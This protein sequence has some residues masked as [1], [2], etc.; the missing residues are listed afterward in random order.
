M[1]LRC[2]E[3]DELRQKE[4][5]TQKWKTKAA[6]HAK[7]FQEQMVAQVAGQ[8]RAGDAARG[9][10][11]IKMLP[12]KLVSQ[13]DHAPPRPLPEPVFIFEGGPGRD[14]GDDAHAGPE[15]ALQFQRVRLGEQSHVEPLRRGAQERRGNGEVAQPPQ[16]NDEQFGF[17]CKSRASCW[18][19]AAAWSIARA[20]LA[21]RVRDF[22]SHAG[23]GKKSPRGKLFVDGPRRPRPDEEIFSRL[24]TIDG[25]DFR[26]LRPDLTRMFTRL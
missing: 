8:R 6:L 13:P 1:R 22:L 26:T 15:A 20:G 10:A 12:R 14:E 25:A 9:E 5:A 24:K 7:K 18:L 21:R 16:F 3:H 23:R 11:E 17:Q 4:A 19:V 2:R